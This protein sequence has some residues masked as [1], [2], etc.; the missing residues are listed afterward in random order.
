MER[1]GTTAC[2]LLSLCGSGLA[3]A[4]CIRAASW[5]HF[6]NCGLLTG[7]RARFTPA[8]V[9]ARTVSSPVARSPYALRWAASGPLSGSVAAHISMGD[10][11]PPAIGLV[12]SSTVDVSSMCCYC[13][14]LPGGCRRF[15]V[16][17]PTGSGD[18]RAS[19]PPS[20]PRGRCRALVA[21][22]PYALS[23]AASGP[24]SGSV[25]VGAPVGAGDARCVVRPQR[26]Q[27][28]TEESVM[29]C[30]YLPSNEAWAV[31]DGPSQICRYF[32]LL[33]FGLYAGAD[34]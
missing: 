31:A 22:S 33:S 10:G 18:V 30:T 24:L 32:D 13:G 2:R 20:S 4:R 26:H 3:E 11:A 21:R 1:F 28:L 15:G 16:G 23:W 7:R 27:H 8:V 17:L 25:A 29:L 5:S 19:L 9:P 6:F 14:L 34:N 12:R